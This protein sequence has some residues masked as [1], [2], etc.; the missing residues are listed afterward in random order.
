MLRNYLITALRNLSRNKLYAAINVIGL[1][2]GFAAAI[3]AALFVRDELTYDRWIPGYERVY[4]V[5]TTVSG[6]RGTAPGEGESTY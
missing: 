2:M 5:T 6:I 3:F 1:A 4:Q